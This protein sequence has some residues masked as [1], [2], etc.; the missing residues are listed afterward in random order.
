MKLVTV[1][2]I[3]GSGKTT[4]IRELIR[5]FWD[6]GQRSAVIVNQEGEEAYTTGFLESH[7]VTIF[8]FQGG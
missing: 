2:G 8:R 7:E 6:Q 1:A 4:L 5:R 3:Q